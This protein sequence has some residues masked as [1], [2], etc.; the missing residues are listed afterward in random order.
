MTPAVV[1]QVERFA[2]GFRD[3]V[4]ASA[5]VPA[6]ELGRSDPNYAGGDIAAGA[7][8]AW[9]TVC[10]PVPAWDPYVLPADGL[11]LCSASV[12]PGPGVHGMAGV[13]VASR[14]LRRQFGITCDPLELVRQD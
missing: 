5:A 7:M 4:L 9:Q 1:A 2:P 13:H 8:S 10:R 12:P 3:L 11:Y 6:Q 14:V